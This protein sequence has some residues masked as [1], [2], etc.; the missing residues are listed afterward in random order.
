M[1]EYIRSILIALALPLIGFTQDKPAP[2]LP[3]DPQRVPNAGEREPG[4]ISEGAKTPDPK[5]EQQRFVGTITTLSRDEKIITIQDAKMGTH[6]L[7][8]AD[9]TKILRGDKVATW[10]DLKVGQKVEGTCHG[11]KEMS[12]A[13]ILTIKD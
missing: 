6:K 13:E 7:H 4:K 9:T 2:G 11:T 10:D 12:H 3:P 8:I 1:K 5:V